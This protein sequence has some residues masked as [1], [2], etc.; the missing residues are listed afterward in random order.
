MH[1]VLTQETMGSNP[2]G[3]IRPHSKT[4]NASGFCPGECRFE[5]GWGHKMKYDILRHT[6][7]CGFHRKDE[8]KRMVKNQREEIVVHEGRKL[9]VIEV[10]ETGKSKEEYEFEQWSDEEYCLKAVESDGDALRYV[11][12]QTEAICIKAVESYGYA[13]RY[14]KEQTEAI[15]IKAVE[16]HGDALRY[17]KE[18]TEAICIKAVESD[19]YALQYVKEQTEAISL[20]A[21]KSYGDALQY[22]KEQTEAICIKAVES[23][24]DALRYVKEKSIFLKILKKRLKLRVSSPI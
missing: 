1:L 2:I 12:E 9:K 16:S 17:V 7:V 21:V 20:K 18:Q 22:V 6:K 8:V 5:S 13:L 14:V 11:K 23:Y 19:G 4:A 10:I 15:C 24:G 3:T